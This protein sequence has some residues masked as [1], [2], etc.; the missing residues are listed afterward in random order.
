M[1]ATDHRE[2]MAQFLNAGLYLVTS[3][4]LSAGRR[5]LDIVEQALNGGVRLIQLREKEL[6]TASFTALAHEV[7]VLTG[8]RDAL[9]IVNDRLDV[10]LSVG[11]DGVHLGQDDL[12]VAEAR[13]LAPELI[14][15][16][17]THSEE[18][19]QAAQAAGAS[20]V[21]IGPL[22]PTRTKEW[23]GAYLGWEGLERLARIATVPY[24]VMGGIKNS[25]IPELTKKGVRTIAVV[26]AV[27][28]AAQ[29]EQ[30]ARDLLTLIR[31]H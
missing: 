28:G 19:L 9:F 13:R 17:S 2:R 11:A 24:T 3:Q 29:P 25:H 10:A 21:N 30:A 8:A 22:F 31:K 5:T 7:R 23:T 27:T 4:P 1:N 12:P 15:G 6:S 26:T 18:E 14:I 20:Y 16:A